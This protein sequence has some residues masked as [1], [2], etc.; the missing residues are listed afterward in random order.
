[1][2]QTTMSMHTNNKQNGGAPNGSS[3]VNAQPASNVSG[4]NFGFLNAKYIFSLQFQN[5]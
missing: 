2:Q 3:L 5:H 4:K 1:M